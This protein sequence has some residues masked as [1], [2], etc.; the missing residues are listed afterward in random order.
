MLIEI[1]DVHVKSY[2]GY[3]KTNYNKSNSINVKD[4]N[5]NGLLCSKNGNRAITFYIKDYN[6][7][8]NSMLLSGIVPGKFVIFPFKIS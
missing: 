7:L 1:E 3:N 6:P 2:K 5:Y 8:E 4:S